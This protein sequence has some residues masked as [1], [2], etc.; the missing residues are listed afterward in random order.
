[1]KII[2]SCKAAE[3]PTP[4]LNEKE[5]G[6]IV[7]LFKDKFSE[8]GLRKIG[9]NAR[10]IKAV[11]YVKEKGRITNKEYQEINQ[12]SKRTAVYELIELVETYKIFKQK[13][14]SVGTYY[15]IE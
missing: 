15:E 7:T 5:G 12:I 6:F 14:E 8:E 3:L 4:E 2:N 9:L 1:M 11:L 13:G 10:Q